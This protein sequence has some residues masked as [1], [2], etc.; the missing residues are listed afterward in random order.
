MRNFALNP[1]Y[2]VGVGLAWPGRKIE[3]SINARWAFERLES[4]RDIETVVQ[5][6]RAWHRWTAAGPLSMLGTWWPSRSFGLHLFFD[7]PLTRFEMVIAPIDWRLAFKSGDVGGLQRTWVA[8]GP[9]R[10]SSAIV[11]IA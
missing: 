8:F 11:E 4:G 7:T 6:G 1:G 10:L 2:G 5:E 9:F 3:T